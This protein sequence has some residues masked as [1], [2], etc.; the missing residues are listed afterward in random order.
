MDVTVTCYCVTI[1]VMWLGFLYL[2]GC[3]SSRLSR[4]SL[5]L[6]LD[7]WW[8]YCLYYRQGR[9]LYIQIPK[10]QWCE[11]MQ[12]AWWEAESVEWQSMRTRST[13]KETMMNQ[14]V[15]QAVQLRSQAVTDES[16]VTKNRMWFVMMGKRLAKKGIGY[17][18]WEKW[19]SHTWPY[20]ESSSDKWP[21]IDSNKSEAYP[22]TIPMIKYWGEDKYNLF[23]F[24]LEAGDERS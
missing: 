9:G 8:T 14:Q 16:E 3:M 23:G 2:T 6:N 11:T 13:K 22:G 24:N 15:N 20:G 12:Y 1:S 17:V 7:L 21:I 18:M 19:M 4:T 5:D 10:L